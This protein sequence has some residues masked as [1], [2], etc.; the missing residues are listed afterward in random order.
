MRSHPIPQRRRKGT[1]SWSFLDTLVLHETVEID[2]PTVRPS[3]HNHA[4]RRG[5]RISQFKTTTGKL[6]ITRIK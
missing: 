5:I 3:A 4:R 6:K 1:A 2:P